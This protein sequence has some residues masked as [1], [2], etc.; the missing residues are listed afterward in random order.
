MTV[1]RVFLILFSPFSREGGTWINK[2]DCKL[3]W[4]NLYYN[5]RES[6]CELFCNN[7]SSFLPQES[8]SS[9]SSSLRLVKY[10]VAFIVN[11]PT[12][13]IFNSIK[14]FRPAVCESSRGYKVQRK[15]EKR[16]GGGHNLPAS[17]FFAV[18]NLCI[19]FLWAEKLIEWDQCYV[20]WL[21]Q[22]TH[23]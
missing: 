7:K 9:L 12:Q 23:A 21:L 6:R 5:S 4:E 16:G 20:L 18:M 15:R 1:A 14:L 3:K 22:P 19:L 17:A 2:L 11:V 13:G 10:P 8:F